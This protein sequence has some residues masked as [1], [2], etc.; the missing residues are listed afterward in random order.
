[1]VRDARRARRLSH[2]PQLRRLRDSPSFLSWR[3]VFRVY[4]RY[5]F[6]EWGNNFINGLFLWFLA[7]RFVGVYGCL[8]ARWRYGLSVGLRA[9]VFTCLIRSQTRARTFAG[10]RTNLFLVRSRFFFCR[11]RVRS[12][13][14]TDS[15]LRTS[16][17]IVLRRVFAI[18]CM[19]VR[20]F[21]FLPD[22]WI[23]RSNLIYC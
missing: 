5:H 3:F 23:F 14:F 22:T 11:A 19:I 21:D 13:A 20:G 8:F 4:Y 15:N 7:V 2:D 18:R 1:M 10:Q 17:W 9:L 6:L 12:R 16:G